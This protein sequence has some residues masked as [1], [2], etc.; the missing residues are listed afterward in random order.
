MYTKLRQTIVIYDYSSFN[1]DKNKILLIFSFLQNKIKKLK[2]TLDEKDAFF[3]Q[4]D[5]EISG[6]DEDKKNAERLIQ[7][8]NQ[9]IISMNVRTKNI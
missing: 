5:V 9:Q 6:L 3:H 7:Q 2:Q 1:L 4:Y 8:Y